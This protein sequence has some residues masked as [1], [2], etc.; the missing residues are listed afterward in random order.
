MT[1]NETINKIH[2]MMGEMH[3]NVKN[4]NKTQ[5]YTLRT[6]DGIKKTLNEV[7]NLSQTTRDDLDDHL[8]EHES[9]R[10]KIY[11]I[12]VIVLTQTVAFIYFI[13][14]KFIRGR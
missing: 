14:S 4:I 10:N 7:K 11:G 2:L 6:M 5:K 12:I 8:D 3:A 1:T 13:A 9:I